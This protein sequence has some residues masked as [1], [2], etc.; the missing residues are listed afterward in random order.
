MSFSLQKNKI[1][2]PHTGLLS[3]SL[4]GVLLSAC[5]TPQQT[6][7][8]ADELCTGTKRPYTVM[9]EKYVPQDHYHYD[10]KGKASWYGP[11]F[12]GRPGSCGSK[13]DMHAYTAAHKTL[14]IP[15]VVEVTNEENG[16]QVTL[17]VNDRGP[18]VESRIIDLS[19]KAAHELGTYQKG[20]SNVRVRALPEESLALATH[21]KKYGR[22]GI[23][24]SGRSW[25]VIY[26]EEVAGKD[27]SH[28]LVQTA[29]QKEEHQDQ[30]D[31]LELAVLEAME[32]S[33]PEQKSEPVVQT[34]SQVSRP[35]VASKAK[36]QSVS[37]T[38][39]PLS[40]VN[41]EEFEVLIEDLTVKNKGAKIKKIGKKPQTKEPVKISKK[42][43]SPQGQGR[44]FIQ[45]GSFV[46]KD[47]AQK[48]LRSLSAYGN[49]RVVQENPQ[50]F[51]VRLGPYPSPKRAKQVMT[52]VVNRGHH[53]VRVIPG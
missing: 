27:Q 13:Y 18:F 47:N 44:H 50:F 46:N 6:I 39:K 14:P 42:E 38:P 51:T 52:T 26:R 49:G 36:V 16:K 20:V 41:Q 30:S 40:P 37:Y 31:A 48:L 4:L 1:K 11:G 7:K 29:V 23:D 12:H 45:V 53:G 3:L 22:Y 25:D 9:G 19:K 43:N 5:S 33:A 10:E 34:I 15:S 24:P 32:H 2:I 17:V 28:L 8:P 35:V 21:L